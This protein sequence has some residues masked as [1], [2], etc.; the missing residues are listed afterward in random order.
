MQQ[1]SLTQ[2]SIQNPTCIGIIAIGV[3]Q[4]I[5]TAGIDL[6]SGPL[7]AATAMI[8]MSFAQTELANG[9]PNP[10]AIFGSWAMD[11]PVIIPVVIGVAFGAFIGAVNGTF[12][13]YF[14]NGR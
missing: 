6:S 13:A 10:K 1:A 5:I 12:V 11:L 7:V 14:R 4:V 3:T 8:A 2:T 9:N